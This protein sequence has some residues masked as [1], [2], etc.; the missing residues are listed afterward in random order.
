MLESL[1]YLGGAICIWWKICTSLLSLGLVL[2]ICKRFDRFM[3]R[4]SYFKVTD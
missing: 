3:K 1:F 4:I 2:Y